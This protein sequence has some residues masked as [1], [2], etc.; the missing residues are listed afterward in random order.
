MA[1][2]VTIAEQR[3]GYFIVTLVGSLNSQTAAEGE[4]QLAPLLTGK[5]Q[6]VL[7]D[8][9]L[10]DYISSMGLRLI[11]K[12]RKALE[13][14]KGRLILANLQPQIAKVFEI[15][16]ALPPQAVFASVAEADRYFDII[17]RREL[18]KQ[19]PPGKRP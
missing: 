4:A 1:L 16:K 11:L 17:Q 9:A 5:A 18:E 12:T 13:A 8:L 2:Q 7:L 10:L 15:A 3:T 19:S 14:R 6:A